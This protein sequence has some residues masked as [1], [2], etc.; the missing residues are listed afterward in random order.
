MLKISVYPCPKGSTD[1]QQFAPFRIG[2]IKLLKINQVF[3]SGN[4]KTD[5]EQLL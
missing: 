4:L 5:N 3:F 1:F 2:V